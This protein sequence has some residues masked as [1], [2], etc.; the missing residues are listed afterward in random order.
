MESDEHIMIKRGSKY[1]GLEGNHKGDM[2]D[3]GC[4]LRK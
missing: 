2:Y 3:F 4:K 1:L